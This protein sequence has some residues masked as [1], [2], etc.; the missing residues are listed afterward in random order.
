MAVTTSTDVYWDANGS[1]L[2]TF[3]YNVE[4]WGATRET[5]PPMRGSNILLPNLPGQ[6]YVPKRPDER[7]ITLSMWVIGANTDGS[8]PKT[9]TARALFEYNWKTLRNLLCDPYRQFQLTKRFRE[10][11]SNTV[12]TATAMAEYRGGLDLSMT[13]DLRGIFTVDLALADPYFYEPAVVTPNLTA[14]PQPMTLTGDARSHKIVA[15]IAG[16]PITNPQISV[17]TPLGSSWVQL[18]DTVA[19]AT[20]ATLDCGL[21]TARNGSNPVS[22]K[23]QHSGDA[24]WLYVEPGVNNFSVTSSSGSATVSL[25]IQ[26]AHI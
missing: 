2:Q 19:A 1:P 9:G 4:S 15:T 6:L 14:T 8:A 12:V 24:Q 13:G 25:S 5:P 3:A 16:G 10:Y 11:G 26:K 18:T 20:T 7:V 17:A 23:I 22:A 21:M